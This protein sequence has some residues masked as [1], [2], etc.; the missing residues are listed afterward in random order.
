M[1]WATATEDERM[2]EGANFIALLWSEIAEKVVHTAAR[3]YELSPEQE[4]ALKRA[5]RRYEIRAV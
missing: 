4:A 1:Q 3:V 2:R 5:F